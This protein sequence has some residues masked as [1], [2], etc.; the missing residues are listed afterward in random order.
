MIGALV[1]VHQVQLGDLRLEVLVRLL[2]VEHLFPGLGRVY[3]ALENAI[4]NGSINQ[5]VGMVVQMARDNVVRVHRHRP[6][7]AVLDDQIGVEHGRRLDITLEPQCEHLSVR[8]ES[9]GDHR[10]CIGMASIAMVGGRST[11]P[12]QGGQHGLVVVRQRLVVRY[13]LVQR[14]QCVHCNELINN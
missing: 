14:G 6:P 5:T 12:S 8:T 7:I 10:I 11:G 13:V 4:A 3:L 9:N 2:H 1:V